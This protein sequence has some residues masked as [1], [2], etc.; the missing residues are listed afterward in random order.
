MTFDEKYAL[1]LQE[2]PK[3]KP[4]RRKSGMGAGWLEYR[5]TLASIQRLLREAGTTCKFLEARA[6]MDK[7]IEEERTP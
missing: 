5:F 4:V 6:L 2:L 7:L 1:L 3:W